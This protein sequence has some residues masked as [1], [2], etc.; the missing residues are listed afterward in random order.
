MF[1]PELFRIM[2]GQILDVCVLADLNG[3]GGAVVLS[4]DEDSFAGVGVE[5]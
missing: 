1:K 5:G 4:G 3:V 2:L